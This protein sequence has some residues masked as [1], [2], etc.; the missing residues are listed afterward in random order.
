MD[1][2]RQTISVTAVWPTEETCLLIDR[3]LYQKLSLNTM[4]WLIFSSSLLLGCVFSPLQDSASVYYDN[5]RFLITR[6]REPGGA[7][8]PT[9][10]SNNQPAV[11]PFDHLHEEFF[12]HVHS[13]SS[14]QFL[15][16]ELLRCLIRCPISSKA[17]RRLAWKWY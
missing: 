11:I 8:C 9:R 13:E 6:S 3:V 7:Q 10:D 17:I 12:L 1:A 14:K 5:S 2:N 16:L 15:P 4:E